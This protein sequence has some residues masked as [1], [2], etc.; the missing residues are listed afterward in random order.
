MNRMQWIE[1]IPV[2]MIS[3]EDSSQFIQ[4]AYEY[5]ASDY[6]ARPFDARV[7][8]QRVFNTIKLYAKQR[9]LLNL[10]TAQV[11]E[12]ERSNRIMLAILSQIV[13]FRN[14]ESGLHVIH[15]NICLL[16]TSRCV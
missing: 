4:K 9:R 13:E 12:K 7:V 16:Y 1:D 5:G 3:S 8:Y 11:Y 10:V 15:I 14:G 6:I 2:I